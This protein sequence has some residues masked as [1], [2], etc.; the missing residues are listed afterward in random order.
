MVGHRRY[1]KG[2]MGLSHAPEAKDASLLVGIDSELHSRGPCLKSNHIE[3]S[4]VIIIIIR[5]EEGF[6][7][8][9]DP[10]APDL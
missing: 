5:I 1:L 2:F 7:P 8:A 3:Y 6:K 10:G 9:L 4:P